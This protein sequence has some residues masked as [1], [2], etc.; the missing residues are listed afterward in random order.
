VLPKLSTTPTSINYG[1]DYIFIY[2]C[3]V[4]VVIKTSVIPMFPKQVNC[5][6]SRGL[7]ELGSPSFPL[8]MPRDP[9]QFIMPLQWTM[10]NI[11]PLKDLMPNIFHDSATKEKVIG[12]FIMVTKAT[13][14][15]HIRTKFP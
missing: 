2:I 13:F 1:V 3:V 6:S 8:A 11:H 4:Y 14:S 7:K 5:F 15:I 12:G 9:L 10:I